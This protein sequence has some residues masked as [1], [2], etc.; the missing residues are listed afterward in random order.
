MST[1]IGGTQQVHEVVPGSGGG[2]GAVSI[3]D[4]SDVAEGTKA[5]VVWDGVTDATVISIL[6]K[7]ATSGAA[8]GLTDAQL[9]ASAVAISG[10]LTDAQL[11]AS[12]V[13]VSA[14]SLPLPSGA[15]TSAN[16]ASEVASLASIDGKLTSPI[17]VTPSLP[18]G[19]STAGNQATEI[20]SLASI[21]GKL[22]NPITIN[23]PSGASTAALQTTGNTSVGNIDTKTPPLGQAVAGASTPVVLPAAQITTLTPPAAITGFALDAT[24]ATIAK[25]ATVAK[26]SSLLTIDTDIKATQPRSITNF[27]TVATIDPTGNA[28]TD[29]Y[30][31]Y[32]LQEKNFITNYISQVEAMLSQ[33]PH[34]S[35]AIGFEL[36]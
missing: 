15:A 24:L 36:R 13:P 31:S 14:S 18:L 4:G 20:A 16:Q 1:S 28:T 19:A 22:T 5:D 8:A 2:G 12:A 3:A 10:A 30:N 27:P 26:D 25:D 7:I 34:T 21:D 33:E 9:R 35:Q 11:R 29:A 6:K 32:R 17:P 23:L